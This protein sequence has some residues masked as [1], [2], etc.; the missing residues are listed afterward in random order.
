[1]SKCSNKWIYD[2][3][4]EP[5]KKDEKKDEEKE[6]ILQI[7]FSWLRPIAFVMIGLI[8]FTTFIGQQYVVSG[9]SM[10]TTLYGGD[11]DGEKL[12][13]DRVYASKISVP[14]GIKSEDIVIVD[15][16]IEYKRTLTDK[17]K[18]GA[19]IANIIRDES[20]L[21]NTWIKRVVGVAG[22]VVSVQGGE[23]YING[24][25]VADA[26][27]KELMIW[28]VDDYLVP[29]GHVYVMGDNRNNS[30]DSR[31]IGAI[32]LENV[33]AKVIFRFY[34]YDNMTKF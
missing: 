18:E 11:A 19:F 29:D 5:S 2:P 6:T 20:N 1:M 24:E 17:I 34:P 10:D 30:G 4:K 12:N 25:K 23:L 26:H 31:V 9:S 32:P 8:I 7:I 16:R 13:G 33:M 28:D 15:K 14:F 21:G 27:K 22:D 3:N